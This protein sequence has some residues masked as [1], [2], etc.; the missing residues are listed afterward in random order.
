[1]G[2]RAVLEE[3]MRMLVMWGSMLGITWFWHWPVSNIS[4]F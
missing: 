4:A 3:G 1:M 2:G